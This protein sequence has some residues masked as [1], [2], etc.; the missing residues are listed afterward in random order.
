MT[1]RGGG[2]GEKKENNE[3]SEEDIMALLEKIKDASNGPEFV[4]R[5][6]RS[7]LW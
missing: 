5:R 6:V 3:D 7:L 2:G 1:D 4:D